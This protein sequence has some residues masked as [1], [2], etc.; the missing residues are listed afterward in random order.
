M[1][2]RVED[3]PA[4]WLT[5]FDEPRA[6]IWVVLQAQFLETP[7]GFN[8][9]MLS[10]LRALGSEL[11]L[12]PTARARMGKRVIKHPVDGDGDEFLT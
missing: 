9:A 3:T 6:H 2:W 12:D 5:R 7:S 1:P 4:S 10:Q 8:A 11:G